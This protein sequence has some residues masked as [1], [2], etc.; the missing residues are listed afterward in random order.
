MGVDAGFTFVTDFRAKNRAAGGENV[1]EYVGIR[2][3]FIP[4]FSPKGVEGVAEA[5]LK[6]LDAI[7]NI[8]AFDGVSSARYIEYDTQVVFKDQYDG[9]LTGNVPTGRQASWARQSSS[10][11]A[12]A[13]NRGAGVLERAVG[14][15]VVHRRRSGSAD[16]G[17]AEKQASLK[18][19][20]GAS[21]FEKITAAVKK[22]QG[23]KLM[24][25]LEGA[26]NT[27]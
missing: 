18:R 24:G 22:S 26:L 13:A 5:H 7:D 23:E 10:E 19:S 21:N 6:M 20:E 8:S 12:E 27:S 4:E 14:G 2:L 11:G 16:A 25:D 15:A 17:R 3:Q 9:Y 1:G